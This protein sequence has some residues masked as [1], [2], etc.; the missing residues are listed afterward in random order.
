MADFPT[1]TSSSIYREDCSLQ[2][3]EDDLEYF[4]TD[5]LEN[6]PID[7]PKFFYFG[8]QSNDVCHYLD[9]LHLV[10][11]REISAL[12]IPFEVNFGLG[13]N[14]SNRL[15]YGEVWYT[16]L[17]PLMTPQDVPVINESRIPIHTQLIFPN[18]NTSISTILPPFATPIN[19]P[20]YSN[21]YF[22]RIRIG[23]F[24]SIE[25]TNFLGY[26]NS[27]HEFISSHENENSNGITSTSSNRLRNT[28]YLDNEAFKPTVDDKNMAYQ[29]RINE[30]IDFN[31]GQKKTIFLKIKIALPEDTYGKLFINPDFENQLEIPQSYCDDQDNTFYFYDQ[32]FGH[33][34]NISNTNFR[35]K[36]GE[37]IFH[38]KIYKNAQSVKSAAFFNIAHD[39][40]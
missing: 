33:V 10:Y 24:I 18:E 29:L 35:L 36:Y 40:D 26:T 11:T 23:K 31:I 20:E 32:I 14:I 16:W 39:D 6:K 28:F 15:L 2:N 4:F 30:N 27:S 38:L 3:K 1:S 17:N 37:I 12:N 25:N 9:F 8:N 7:L 5:Q 13:L 34:K 22:A 21:S 19:I